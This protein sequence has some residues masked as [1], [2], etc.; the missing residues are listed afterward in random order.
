MLTLD[1]LISE[2]TALPD[3]AKA[4]L[5]DKVMESMEGQIDQELLT[6]G[7]RKAQERIAEIDRGEVQTIPGDIALAQVRQILL[8]LLTTPVT[9][10]AS[11]NEAALLQVIQQ[12][13]S[14]DQQQRVNELRDRCEWGEL[15][16]QEQQELINY[17]DLLE[18]QQVARLNALIQLANC[19]GISPLAINHQLKSENNPAH[20]A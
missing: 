7:L 15:T 8:Q 12:S 1:Q 13:L 5:V 6:E 11:D 17:E 18:E 16:P 14:I 10:L 19:A 2:A 9:P 20:A 4:I 3:A